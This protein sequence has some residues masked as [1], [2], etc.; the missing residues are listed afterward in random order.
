[1]VLRIGVIGTG[2]IGQEHIERLSHKLIGSQVVAVNDINEESA[3]SAIKR[4]GIEATFYADPHALIKAPDIDA[5]VVTSWG[6]SH[7]E[8]VLAAIAA[9][10][11]V[12]CEKPLAVT[13][14]G[15]KKIVDAEI[16]QGKRLVQVGFMR[17]F[18]STYRQLKAV[19]DG[20]KI[21]QP[22]LV[23]CKHFNPEVGDSYTTDMAIID[24]LIHELDVLRWLLNDDYVAA[25]VIFPKKT[26]KAAKHLQDPQIVILETVKGI[27]I[28]AQIFVNC[29]Y[30][31][32]IQC[33]VIG[34]SG[35]A[36]L[37]EPTQVP[38]RKDGN[39]QR[40]I[41]L[42]WKK[43]FI[44]AYDVELQAF[45]NNAV[46]GKF[47]HGG[48]TAWDGYAAAVAADACVKAQ[49]TGERELI[50]MPKTPDFYK[51]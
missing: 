40:E 23:N 21:G 50:Q 10:K 17:P 24:T 35:I 14:E 4:L 12:F 25:R 45:I 3:K 2:A 7:E 16:A 1:M 33:E 15:C 31:Y 41:L 5:I 51:K 27:V 19:L 20:N 49:Q 37:P 26:S 6:P 29:L 39:L 48:A 22:L 8:F 34:E 44:D 38:L 43:R 28:N 42:D 30:G 46:S 13:A 32:D 36:S 11:P 18:D 47:T 9:G